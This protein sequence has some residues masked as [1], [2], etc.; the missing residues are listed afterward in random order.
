MDNTMEEML[1]KKIAITEE[2]NARLKIQLEET[3]AVT[4]E[5]Q[6]AIDFVLMNF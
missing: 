4:A 3:Q 1:L 2:E 5:N 6:G